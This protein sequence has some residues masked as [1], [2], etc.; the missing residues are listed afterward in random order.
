MDLLF[1]LLMRNAALALVVATMLSWNSFGL[2]EETA[3]IPAQGDFNAALKKYCFACHDDATATAK[4]SLESLSTPTENHQRWIAVYD[5]LR[6][7]QM[8]P[9][10][11]PQPSAAERKQMTEWIGGR[12]H[13]A[14]LELQRKE[15]RVVL[16]RLN[17][18]EYEQTLRD[19]LGKEVA[20]RSLLP[21]DTVAAGFDN[22][23]EVLDISSVHL[24]RYQDAAEKALQSAIPRQLP[25][26]IK[27]RLTGREVAAKARDAPIG[28][29]LRI[30]GDVLLIYAIPYG[31]IPLGTATVPQPG[32]YKLRASMYA[33][34]TNGHPL[35]VRL[36]AG[37]AWG[38]D[39]KSVLAVRDVQADKPQVI[40]EECE[41][42]ANDLVDVH[43]WTLPNQRDF[44]ERQ[45][46]DGKPLDQYEGPGL[47][48]EWLEIEGPLDAFPPVGYT[49]LFGDLPL[50]GKY[51][52]DRLRPDSADPRADAERLMQRFLPLA[53]SRP[54]SDELQDYYLK[55][56]LAELDRKQ[57]FEDAMLLGYRAALCSPHFLFLNEPL[58]SEAKLDDYAVAARLSYFFW[59]TSPDEELIEL[60]AKGELTKPAVLKSEVERLLNDPRAH[61]FTENFVGQWLDLRKIDDTTPDPKLYGEYDDFLFWSMPNETNRFFEEILRHDRPLTDFTHSDWS[62]LNER[63]AKHY[64]IPGVFGGE[65]RVV[66]LPPE[67][68]RGG[69]M[70]QASIMK[71]TADGTKTSP[72]LRGKWVL[73]K[74]LGQPPAPPPPN[75]SA[76]EPDIRGATTIR[77]QLDK[78]RDIQSC[79]ACHRHIDP[80]GFALE[81]Y[82][83]IGG[84]REFYR[85]TKYNREALV[86]LANY[87]GREVVRGLDVEQGGE[88]ADGREFKNVDDY[89]Q[90]LMADKDQLARNL[91][92]K[93]L[94]YATGAEIQFADREV[95]EDLVRKS[96]AK[97]FGFRSLVHDVVQS[98]IFLHK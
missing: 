65:L 30:D 50:K 10:D 63:L 82:D 20:V 22:V 13:E 27:T 38:R 84:Y 3:S 70:T 21:E 29:S 44:N 91:A 55:I 17:V 43:G 66:K 92:E 69:V 73:E 14:S 57:H 78:H 95:V 33:V 86:K 58:G 90:L 81:S 88:T 60:A 46:K 76:I 28:Q 9:Q 40:E 12:L 1:H 59:S 26:S 6:L 37:K 7:G 16:R 89:K 2:A 62:C 72:V 25:K 56:V 53:F 85:A 48:V 96:R 49:N 11:E 19:L 79:A 8:P 71:V 4:L 68:H 61:R 74:I 18:T 80:P 32:R 87:P 23:S 51:N 83:V 94:I 93:L 24:L 36:S 97:N 47:A 15:G 67:S 5:K 34:G 35:P 98:R 39:G 52:G 75:V 41:L 45:K 54:V 31:H 77:Q 64:D 42:G